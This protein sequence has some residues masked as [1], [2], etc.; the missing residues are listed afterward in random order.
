MF[1]F[2]QLPQRIPGYKSPDIVAA[3]KYITKALTLLAP[4]IQTWRPVSEKPQ[5][6]KYYLVRFG[7]GHTGYLQYRHGYYRIDAWTDPEEQP[8]HYM[9]IVPSTAHPYEQL[10]ESLKM[11]K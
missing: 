6:N 9:E 3:R 2:H 10:L 7:K 4:F 1:P 5:A 11:Q 8:T